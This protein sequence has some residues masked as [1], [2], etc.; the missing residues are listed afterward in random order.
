[1]FSWLFYFSFQTIV[2][3]STNYLRFILCFFY[4]K[5]K[6]VW[7]SLGNKKKQKSNI[8]FLWIDIEKTTREISFEPSVKNVGILS[9]DTGDSD[10]VSFFQIEPVTPH[11]HTILQ[12]LCLP[13]VESG[14]GEIWT[15]VDILVQSFCNWLLLFCYC[16]LVHETMAVQ[17][18]QKLLW[19]HDEVLVYSWRLLALFLFLAANVHAHNFHYYNYIYNP[20]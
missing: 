10:S 18:G 17:R 11:S 7:I 15:P 9:T 13:C 3:S 16:F 1:M 4:L 6:K 8:F 20:L 14:W 12:S 2:I 5:L 19:L